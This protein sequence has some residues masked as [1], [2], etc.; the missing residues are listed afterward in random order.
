MKAGDLDDRVVEFLAGNEAAVAPVIER[1]LSSAWAV[2]LAVVGAPD[3]A[4]DVCQEA[5]IKCWDRRDQCRDP[6]KFRGWLLTIVRNTAQSRIRKG[7]GRRVVPADESLVATGASPQRVAEQS[8][9][10]E[11]L[12]LAMG[13]LTE[14]Q[15]EVLLLRDMEG[16]KH[17]E[18]AAHLGITEAMSRRHLSDGRKKMRVHLR[19][20]G[21]DDARF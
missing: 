12:L 1:H 11:V 15:R 5:L 17:S 9:L 4:E 7:A 20:A 3:E 13:R 8:E 10:R 16:W 18:V 21:V 14:V 19:E 2:A 6:R